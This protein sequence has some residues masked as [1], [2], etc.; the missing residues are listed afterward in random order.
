MSRERVGQRPERELIGTGAS[1]AHSALYTHLYFLSAYAGCRDLGW[2]VRC[3]YA[4]TCSPL[5]ES[6]CPPIPATRQQAQRPC[7]ADLGAAARPI[8]IIARWR[9]AACRGPTATTTTASATTPASTSASS[10]SR[11]VFASSSGGP[12][13]CPS[14]RRC[15][16][17]TD[18]CRPAACHAGTR[19]G[20]RGGAGGCQRRQREYS[21]GRRR[22]RRRGGAH[23]RTTGRGLP[24]DGHAQT[25][26]TD[27][28]L[29]APRGKSPYAGGGVCVR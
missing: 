8:A 28:T 29:W 22:A 4:C 20:C 25:R 3:V 10:P 13:R 5:G 9:V 1:A 24:G 12:L 11:P 2:A 26:P 18:T 21:S 15:R 16:L 6:G 17:S 19:G 14:P 27:T 23:A 7:F